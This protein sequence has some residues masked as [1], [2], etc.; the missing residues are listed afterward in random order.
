MRTYGAL[1]RLE[2]GWVLGGLD[3]HVKIK[4]KALFPQIPKG[5]GG[6]YRFGDTPVRC[7]D[8]ACMPDF[9]NLQQSPAGFDGNGNVA[10][11]NLRAARAKARQSTPAQ[12]APLDEGSAQF[13]VVSQ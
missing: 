4:L 8:L 6:P 1:S 12:P 2:D 9:E 7:A 3:P 5:A 10:I 13:R 11:A